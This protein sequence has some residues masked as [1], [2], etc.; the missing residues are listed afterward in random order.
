[1]KKLVASN[2][3]SLKI[4]NFDNTPLLSLPLGEMPNL[5]KLSIKGSLIV[6]ADLRTNYSLLEVAYG[7]GQQ[8]ITNPD[9]VIFFEGK[10]VVPSSVE[11]VK[12]PLDTS[13]YYKCELVGL[14]IEYECDILGDLI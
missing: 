9:V 11:I 12:S 14:G 2:N 13:N 1:M 5:E 8:C 10:R 3:C 4:V 6:H 7:I